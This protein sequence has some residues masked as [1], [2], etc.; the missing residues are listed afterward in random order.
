MNFVTRPI[1]TAKS[2]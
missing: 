2:F 1:L